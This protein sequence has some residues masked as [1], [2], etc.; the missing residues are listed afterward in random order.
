MFQQD[1]T[2]KDGTVKKVMANTEQELAEAVRVAKGDQLTAS[3][4]INNPDHGNVIVKDFVADEA[5]TE[6][7]KPKTVP[8]QKKEV[9]M[10]DNTKLS[11]EQDN[12]SAEKRTEGE[13]AQTEQLRKDAEA[14]EAKSKNEPKGSKKT[15]DNKK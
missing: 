12:E 2:T 1:V 7:Q 5:K 3:P 15:L 11:D 9:D 4:D 14:Q 8:K 6:E 10:T 13:V